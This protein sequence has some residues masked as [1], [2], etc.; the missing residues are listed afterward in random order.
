[1]GLFFG[2]Q[3]RHAGAG[4]LLILARPATESAFLIIFVASVPADGVRRHRARQFGAERRLRG[5][6][7]PLRGKGKWTGSSRRRWCESAFPREVG[8][9]NLTRTAVA[10]RSDAKS[11][12]PRPRSSA[13]RRYRTRGAARFHT[14]CAR[15]HP[16]HRVDARDDGVLHLDIVGVPACRAI[17]HRARGTASITSASFRKRTSGRRCSRDR[18]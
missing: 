4:V 16:R 15:R 2:C 5:G 1:M 18:W 7:L 13:S 14:A 17:A 10:V 11:V 3:P 12:F 8:P 9:P 6:G